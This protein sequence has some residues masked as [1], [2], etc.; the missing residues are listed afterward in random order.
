MIDKSKSVLLIGSDGFLGNW[1]RD[2][3]DENGNKYA[4]YDIQ[5][6]NDIC[7]GMGDIPR[8]DYV[9]NCAGI[10]SPEKYMKQPVETMDVSYIGTKNV[11]DYCVENKVE[12]VLMF[13]SSEVYGTPESISIPTKEDYIGTIPTRSSRSCY[14][15]GK[16]VLETLCHIYHN[17][18]NVPVKVVRPFN[19][20]GAYM[21]IND[22]RVLSNWMRS[23][24]R[25]EDIMIYGDGKQTRTFCY[26]EDGINMCLGVLI[27]GKN[28]EIYNVGNPTPELT[29]IDLATVFCNVLDYN[30]RYVIRDYPNFYPKDE[31]LRR[32]P[33]IDKVVRDTGIQPKTTLDIGLK[34]MLKYFEENEV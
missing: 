4:T 31:P 30:D 2:I 9:I 23:M 10:A 12:S 19:F 7:D 1:F 8:Y 16:Q 24:L 13:S 14:D 11:L 6:G 17:K 21:G 20:Y 3:L 32:C 25:D 18:H 15:I 22:N 26:A 5:S 28:G 33:N 29:M 34:K 27:N